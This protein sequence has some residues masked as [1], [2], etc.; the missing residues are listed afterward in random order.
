MIDWQLKKQNVGNFAKN[1][2]KFGVMPRSC[3]NRL[4][5]AELKY[6]DLI[7][8][9]RVL[10]CSLFDLLLLTFTDRLPPM[11]VNERWLK[12]A[13][14][15]GENLVSNL[16]RPASPIQARTQMI[17]YDAWV[18]TVNPHLT[19]HHSKVFLDLTPPGAVNGSTPDLRKVA[20]AL[21]QQVEYLKT[22]TTSPQP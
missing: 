16:K 10:V 11:P 1:F 13:I 21:K 19:P 17:I 4:L 9:D 20:A 18:R 2:T 12:L 22:I 8:P 14:A 15:D 5:I 3:K 7:A 6:A